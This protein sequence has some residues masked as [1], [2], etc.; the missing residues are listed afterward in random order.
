MLNAHSLVADSERFRDMPDGTRILDYLEE[1]FRTFGATH[2]LATGMPLPGRPVE[3]LVLRMHWGELTDDRLHAGSIDPGD[4]LLR[5]ALR[6]R[7]AF[8]WFDGGPAADHLGEE[9]ALIRMAGP[10]GKVKLVGVPLCA[11]LPYQACVIG[12]GESLTLDTKAMLS[13]GHFCTEA[14][15]QL[16]AGG[17]LTRERPGD[18]SARERRVVELSASGMTAGEIA[19]ILTISQRTVHAHLQNA[20]EKLR[21]SNKTHTVVEALRYGQISV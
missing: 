12:A 13:I 1:R 20:S 10:L 7:R 19:D 2:F 6:S 16:F 18:L 11:F 3:P 14:F 8:A 4:S 9:S 5:H 17:V 15:R 21:A